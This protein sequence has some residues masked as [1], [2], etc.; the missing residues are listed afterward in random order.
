M[1][2]QSVMDLFLRL[3]SKTYPHGMEFDLEFEKYL[4]EDKKLEMDYL[5]NYFIKVGD[6]SV[7]FSSHLDTADCVQK[8]LNHVITDNII[9]TDGTSVLGADDKAG[10]TIMLSMIANNVSGLYYFFV[11]EEVGRYGSSNAVKFFPEVFKSYTKMVSFDRRGCGSII[12]YQY[13]YRTCS[14][15]FATSLM[16]QLNNN[17]IESFL[18][19]DGLA[20]DSYSFMDIIPECTNISVGYFSEHTTME[21]Q[22]IDYLHKLVNVVL[23]IDWESLPVNRDINDVETEW[24]FEKGILESIN[25]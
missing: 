19:V 9:S 12:T 15:I 21:C 23:G 1:D 7:I 13:G 5:G 20:S 16:E 22:D 3:T 17:G 25:G 6:S 11:G 2:K 18:D 4:P 8:N 10:V 24:D 14:D